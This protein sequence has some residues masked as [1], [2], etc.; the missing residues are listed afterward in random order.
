M[1]LNRLEELK[2]PFE[3]CRGQSYDNGANMS[4]KNKGVQARLLEPNPRGLFVS[5]VGHALN[6]VVADAAKGSVDATSYF[7]ILQKLYNLFSVS[8]Q[9]WASLKKHANIT[10]KMWSETRWESKSNSV[11]P[12]RYQAS[13]VR[14][15]LIEVRH[16]TKDSVIKI[17]AQ[18]MSEEVRSYRFSICTVVWYDILNQTHHVSKLMQSPNMHVDVEVN[19]LKKTER[20]LLN[21][22]A[23]GFASA[24]MSAKDM[25]E[26]M[27]VEAVLQQKRLRST[28]RHFSYELFDE[29]LSDALKKLEVTFLMLLLM[30]QCL[31]SKRDSPHWK[32]WER[33]LKY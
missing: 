23:T 1:I 32:M 25:C 27:N 13:A 22:R 24:Q 2:I 16:H 31:P 12:L 26:D 5:C 14:E 11:E 3:D 17:E 15:A 9:R 10:L 18:S 21:Y 7:G 6:L 19:L 29:P 30:L 28:K 33:N 4:R 20:G 8:T